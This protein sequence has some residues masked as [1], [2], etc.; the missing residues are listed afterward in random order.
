MAKAHDL[1]LAAEELRIAATALG[2][3]TGSTVNADEILGQIFS[4]FCIGK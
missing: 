3:V 4:K 2:K 1:V